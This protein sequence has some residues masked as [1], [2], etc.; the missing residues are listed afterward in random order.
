MND[1]QHAIDWHG[2][3]LFRD[4]GSTDLLVSVEASSIVMEEASHAI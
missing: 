1:F 2:Y 4:Q 3:L